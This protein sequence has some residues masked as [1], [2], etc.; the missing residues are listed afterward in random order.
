ML[1]VSFTGQFKKDYKLCK[2]RGYNMELL[3][4]VIDTLAVSEALP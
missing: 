4:S 3:Q 1:Q 2:K